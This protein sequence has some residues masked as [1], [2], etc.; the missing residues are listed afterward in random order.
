[1]P[2][3]PDEALASAKSPTSLPGKE[4]HNK[5][6]LFLDDSDFGI[7]SLNS[8]LIVDSIKSVNF[9]CFQVSSRL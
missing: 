1:M 4:G 3:A 8:G 7:S 5:F 2:H 6:E 9:R